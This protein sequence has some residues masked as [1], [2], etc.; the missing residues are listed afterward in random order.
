MVYI[1]IL[2]LFATF[3]ISYCLDKDW[4]GLANNRSKIHIKIDVDSNN[5]EK[6]KGNHLNL[7]KGKIKE[8]Y[9]EEGENDDDG[10]DDDGDD[11]RNNGDSSI[12][13]SSGSKEGF[14]AGRNNQKKQP[15][16][17]HIKDLNDKG[18]NKLRKERKK[19]S[20]NS[21]KHRMKQMKGR[22]IKKKHENK[23]KR[24]NYENKKKNQ[25]VKKKKLKQKSKKKMGEKQKLSDKFRKKERKKGKFV[26]NPEGR[27]N[28]KDLKI[29]L[30]FNREDIGNK[31]NGSS[32][33]VNDTIKVENGTENKEEKSNEN[34]Q[35]NIKD[36]HPIIEMDDNQNNN[37]IKAV[38]KIRD[39]T[40][41]I[42]IATLKEM[43]DIKDANNSTMKI[44]IKSANN[45]A[46]NPILERL[47]SIAFTY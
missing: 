33:N 10:G 4:T 13:I 47:V 18:A 42:V 3:R 27:P 19:D 41:Q 6:G 9:V 34:R 24:K 36:A 35:T 45:G 7:S 21:K 1:K 29:P 44:D 25:G 40:K 5:D 8:L 43:K 39:L 28:P 30:T 23:Q 20:K 26:P 12:S 2:L 32:E 31:M 46:S 38:N 11:G 17:R 22:K 14:D 16:D 15:N 37:S